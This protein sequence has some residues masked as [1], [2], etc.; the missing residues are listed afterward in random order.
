MR[1]ER[2]TFV[3]KELIKPQSLNS[4]MPK[5][6]ETIKIPWEK[7]EKWREALLFTKNCII[8]FHIGLL[9]QG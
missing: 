7:V 6:S 3:G 5:L 9:D 1:W 2:P 8:E 4:I